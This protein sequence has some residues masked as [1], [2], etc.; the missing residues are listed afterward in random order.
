MS[1]AAMFNGAAVQIEE[2]GMSGATVQFEEDRA[3]AG[4][5]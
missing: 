3:L 1:A 4:I 2:N 5:S